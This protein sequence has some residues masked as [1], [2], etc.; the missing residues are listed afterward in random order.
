LIIWRA[1]RAKKIPPHKSSA[2]GIFAG[3]VFRERKIGFYCLYIA[4]VKFFEYQHFS[5]LRRGDS[6]APCTSAFRFFLFAFIL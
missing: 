4:Q 6:G 1:V 5:N 3:S 2:D